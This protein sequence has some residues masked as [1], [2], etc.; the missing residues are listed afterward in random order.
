MALGPVEKGKAVES[1]RAC[2]KCLAWN[3]QKR[4]CPR[5][6]FPCRVEEDGE[7]C[8]KWHDQ[9]L[10]DSNNRYCEASAVMAD[11]CLGQT[12]ETRVLLP[13][14]E[15]EVRA[16]QGKAEGKALW[17][18]GATICLVTHSW[19]KARGLRGQETSIF[20]KVVHHSHE[21]VKSL[22]Y[23]FEMVDKTGA[24]CAVKA[25]G[26]DSISSEPDFQPTE[27]ILEEFPEVSANQIARKAGDIDVLLGMDVVAWHPRDVATRGNRRLLSS[28]FGTGT[29]LV[30]A[31]PGVSCGALDANA[32]MLTQ[33]RWDLPA[34]AVVSR[35]SDRLPEF[36]ELEDLR[37]VHIP[38]CRDCRGCG[39]CTFRKGAFSPAEAKS[40]ELMEKCMRYDE[41]EQVIHVA[42]PLHKDADSQPN[43]YHQIVAI[44][45]NIEKR[46]LKDGLGEQY[47][48]E[49]QKMLDAGSV[50]KLDKDEASSWTG[51][52][53]YMPH[54][55]VLNKESA[56]TKLRI[57][58]DSK[59]KNSVSKKS[60]KDLIMPVPNAINDIVDVQL[61]WRMFD[62]SLNYD[63]SKA[64]HALRTGPREM[65]LR[66]FI[67]RFDHQSAWEIYAYRVV[68]FGD[69]PAALGLE[70]A[71]ELVKERGKGVDAQ[72]AHQLVKNSL[73]DDVG[74]GG[75]EAEV[76]RMRGEL[77]DGK[78]S[79]TV[80]K[81]L[82]AC[83]FRAKALVR[84]GSTDSEELEALSGR[85]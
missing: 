82:G 32:V 3:H 40:V 10:H 80:P 54:F 44:Q 59:C 83:G 56:S 73:V 75:T 5:R 42:Y 26:V 2:P 68:A 25:L 11:M 55:P 6:G 45:Q 71:K 69:R 20:L 57:V 64:Y 1:L 49:M 19:A 34:R 63:L 22:A 85:F 51:G 48:T 27:E 81:M 39:T 52:V 58:V 74:G 84:S 60:F 77:Q 37:P 23:T 17:D 43:N 35:V 36:L 66:R 46:A 4:F 72:A 31:V 24:R 16:G 62:E 9:M 28:D 15:V 33:A 13:V 61:R 14:Q 18:T 38:L 29:M 30:G 76:R 65:H 53:H 67:Y 79:G 47:N 21:E 78:Y 41:E 50:V 70:L 12:E 8:K 7:K